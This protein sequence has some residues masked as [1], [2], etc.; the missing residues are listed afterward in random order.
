MTRCLEQAR[1]ALQQL[2]RRHLL[3]TRCLG[4]AA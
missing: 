3:M 1:V 2:C 4:Q